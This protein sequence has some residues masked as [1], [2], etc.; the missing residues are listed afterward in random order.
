V[1]FKVSIKTEGLA[2]LDAALGEFKK[3]TA[4]AI[5]KRALMT[6]AQPL[7]DMDS[8]LAPDDPATGPPDLHSSIIASSKLRNE[9]G[10]K[11]FAAVMRA[12]GTRADAR[13]AML[14]AKAVG[15]EDSFAIVYVGPQSGSKKNAIKAIVQE[16]GSVKQPAQPY[17]RPAWEQSQGTVLDG[18]KA[19]LTVEIDKATK[20]AQARAL[21]LAA[22]GK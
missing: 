15:G 22:K 11:E 9:T 19:A 7:V 14:D 8:R 5:L 3:G 2:E 10:N 13:A 1:S 18:I 6:A 4:R 12:G 16:F 21:R 20:R 17:L